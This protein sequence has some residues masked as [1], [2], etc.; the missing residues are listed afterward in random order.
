MTLHPMDEYPGDDPDPRLYDNSREVLL[1]FPDGTTRKGYRSGWLGWCAWIDGL[2]ME[3][4]QMDVEP[5]GWT[6]IEP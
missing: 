2:P 1:H 6:A 4:D 5:I 3:C